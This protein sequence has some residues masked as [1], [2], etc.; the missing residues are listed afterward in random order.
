[1]GAGRQ[2]EVPAARAA[3]P[4][5]AGTGASRRPRARRGVP[6]RDDGRVERQPAVAGGRRRPRCGAGTGTPGASTSI[7]AREAR[8][9]AAGR[10]ATEPPAG[11]A[12]E[13]AV[14]REPVAVGAERQP[15]EVDVD[16]GGPVAADAS[17]FAHGASS[18]RP[19]VAPARSAGEA[20]G[21]RE[22]LPAAAAQRDA[23]HPEL[24]EERGG[25]LA[26]G[27]AHRRLAAEAALVHGPGR[28]GHAV[29]GLRVD[30]GE[31]LGDRPRATCPRRRCRSAISTTPPMIMIPAPTR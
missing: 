28:G 14:D 15:G 12:D 3:C 23:G 19:S 9:A 25:Q 30:G 4:A 16:A 20:A 13:Q 22:V 18:G 27:D 17:R 2:S 1:M 11:S 26:G 5:A 29:A 6:G 31:R 21:Q 7:A 10:A 24:G 8:P